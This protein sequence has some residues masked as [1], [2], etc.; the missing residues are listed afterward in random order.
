MSCWPVCQWKRLWC[1]Y[2]RIRLE[3]W[4]NTL[5]QLST[6]SVLWLILKH[7]PGV[8]KWAVSA[9][10]RR[11]R[12]P[13]MPCRPIIQ[14][15]NHSLLLARLSRGQ[16]PLRRQL[17]QLRCRKLQERD[18]IQWMQ[19]LPKRSLLWGWGREL[20]I[21]PCQLWCWSKDEP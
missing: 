9:L 17:S 12:L 15:R 8:S 5:L 4:I 16:I 10:Y 14:W 13:W 1:L 21:P 20:L 11:W 3:R 19:R 7:V 18:R 6:R 2:Q